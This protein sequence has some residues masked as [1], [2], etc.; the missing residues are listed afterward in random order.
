MLVSG[1]RRRIRSDLTIWMLLL[2]TNLAI[3]QIWSDFLQTNLAMNQIRSDLMQAECDCHV[4]YHSVNILI[5]LHMIT[6]RASHRIRSDLIHSLSRPLLSVNRASLLLPP[7]IKFIL[8]PTVDHWWAS[9]IGFPMQSRPLLSVRSAIFFKIG[10]PMQSRPLLSVRR[11][12]ATILL[13]TIFKK[14]QY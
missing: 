4:T 3:H 14:L 1:Q 13:L 12:S 9:C 7:F 10:F 6:H 11:R 5:T 2:I 8:Q